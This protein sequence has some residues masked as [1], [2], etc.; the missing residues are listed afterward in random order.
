MAT[1]QQGGATTTA[2]PSYGGGG[3][4]GG[5][6]RKKP[7]RKPTTPYERP[8]IA[9]RGN[10]GSSSSWLTKLVVDPASKLIS[11]GARRFFDSVFRKRRLPAPPPPPP[12]ISES[13]HV[14]SGARPDAVLSEPVGGEHRQPISSNGTGIS[15]LEQ[16]LKQNTFSRSEIDHLTELLHSRGGEVSVGGDGKRNE[17]MVSDFER[18]RKIENGMNAKGNEEDRSLRVDSKVLGDGIAS[19]SELAKAYMGSKPSNL[20]QSVLGNH[21]QVT[22]RDDTKMLSNMRTKPVS[23]SLTTRSPVSFGSPGNGHFSNPRSLGRSAI[24]NMA[25]TPYLKSNGINHN[26]HS[27]FLVPSTSLMVS[28]NGEKSE[29][30]SMTLK[31]RSFVLD[32]EIG[33]GG[34]IRRIRQKSNQ[35][36]H[37]IHS[38]RIGSKSDARLV[39][40]KQKLPLI[41]DQE[42]AQKII[43]GNT[44]TDFSNPS[45]SYAIVPSKSN[46][47]DVALGR[48][49]PKSSYSN[50]VA[51]PLKS[52]FMLTP[53]ML[54][55]QALRSMEDATSS[56]LLLNAQDS[57]KFDS[58][59]G[60]LETHDS[61]PQDQGKT[62]ENGPVET[63]SPSDTYNTVNNSDS[64]VSFEASLARG[65]NSDYVEN[66][67]SQPQNK[68]AFRMSALEDDVDFDDDV[69]S[70]GG[71]LEANL[72]DS[73]FSPPEEPKLFETTIQP[74][75][76]SHSDLILSKTNEAS[77]AVASAA[78]S[79]EQNNGFTNPASENISAATQFSTHPSVAALT[80]SKE[81][82]NPPYLFSFS[83]KVADKFPSL[84]PESSTSK[85][86]SSSSLLNVFATASSP[87]TFSEPGKGGYL[88]SLAAE[89]ANGKSDTVSSP[90]SD[91]PL[92]AGTPAVSLTATSN[93]NTNPIS[94]AVP[95]IFTSSVSVLDS[96]PSGTG[97][98]P[99][100]TF[101]KITFGASETPKVS[102][103]TAIKFGVSPDPSSNVSAA[104]TTIAPSSGSS[105]SSLTNFGLF[106]APSSGNMATGLSSSTSNPS[107]N[108]SVGSL[109]GGACKSFA[110]AIGTISQGT[111]TQLNS[112]ASNTSSSTSFAPSLSSAPVSSQVVPFGFNPSASS[113]DTGVVAPSSGSA[114]SLFGVNPTAVSNGSAGGS[115]S[116]TTSSL[117]SFGASSSSS[118]I[119]EVGS[120]GG[121]T[122]PVFGAGLSSSA[123]A[124]VTTGSFSNAPSSTSVVGSIGGPAAPVFSFGASSSGPAPATTN[125]FGS[126]S[127]FTGGATAPA[128]NTA[129]NAV[130]SIG[131][132]APSPFSFGLSNP[133]SAPASNAASPF[134]NG[135]SGLFSFGASSSSSSSSITT[136]VSS[137]SA[138]SNPF[139]SSVQA[140][141]SP[142]FGSSPATGFSFG[143][144][145]TP[146]APINAASSLFGSSTAQP[147]SS[148]F[149]FSSAPASVFSSP[150]PSLSQP[151]FGNPAPSFGASS[152]GNNFQMNGEDSMAEDPVQSTAP[153]LHAFGQASPAPSGFMFGSAAPS[154]PNNLFAFGGQQNQA[155]P[156]PSMFQASNSLDFNAGGSFSLGSGG[157]DKSGRKFVKVNRNKNRRK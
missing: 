85:P 121:A 41:D 50:L 155:P 40:S 72:T 42:H 20:S 68:A 87:V 29:P 137:N 124:S 49:K 151:V 43:E 129:S 94:T 117:F 10:G 93:N 59:A 25:R 98:I 100:A 18:H 118:T 106:G 78:P 11:Y 24:Y 83:S 122:A 65:Q 152:P 37:G 127:S 107:A 45:T 89:D 91:G 26:G 56:E 147:S 112:F 115:S 34:S 82:N 138:P 149:S 16:L 48:L 76:K 154:Q 92:V 17:E 5:K 144:Q 145:P 116:F 97:S 2:A 28:E 125:P 133:S 136:S 88:K 12:Q 84:A 21:S 66:G 52:K 139:G 102:G 74:E 15:D 31:R 19:P 67:L 148:P 111:S 96:V 53:S 62:D 8:P 140:P 47:A 109:F 131:G 4:A 77:S 51:V 46:G 75:L 55:G 36:A 69:P 7:F 99:S 73:K 71:S 135:A 103:E 81:M 27:G 120:T 104:S 126:S 141:S 90:A 105:F 60:L 54:H 79:G 134:S 113:S 80:E 108:N 61:T 130:G 101:G 132:A 9:L 157:V 57:Y 3:G 119:N 95:A 58:G 44:Y 153:S 128:S 30:K 156:N 64:A 32:D 146:S 63:S 22:L 23:M 6:F 33:P 70:I 86:E 123:P 39:S 14:L 1:A 38:D 150:A 142:L 143:A 114:S 13:N 110:P 35:I